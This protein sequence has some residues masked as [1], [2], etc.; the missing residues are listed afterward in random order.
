MKLDWTGVYP[1][2]TTA[3]RADEALDL[4]ATAKHLDVLTRAG[5][6]GL[7][8]LGTVGENHALRY[9]EKLDVLRPYPIASTLHE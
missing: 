4:E 5:V 3:F 1:A 7:V 9:E 8:V 6:H 2:A